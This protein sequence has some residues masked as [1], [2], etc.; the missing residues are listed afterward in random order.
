MGQA[1]ASRGAGPSQENSPPSSTPPESPGSAPRPSQSRPTYAEYKIETQSGTARGGRVITRGEVKSRT[2]YVD[3]K[4]VQRVD[5]DHSHGNMQPYV[6]PIHRNPNN[7]NL[8]NTGHARPPAPGKYLS[9]VLSNPD[10][11]RG[12]HV[13][14]E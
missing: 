11:R 10:I 1:R 2:D 13:P 14:S 7:P 9:P 8:V 4:A 6:H 12:V 5:F 3:S